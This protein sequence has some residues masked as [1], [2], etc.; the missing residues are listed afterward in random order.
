MCFSSSQLLSLV[1]SVMKH[2]KVFPSWS[3]LFSK[4]RSL[5]GCLYIPLNNSWTL[6]LLWRCKFCFWCSDVPCVFA[7]PNPQVMKLKES[8]EECVCYSEKNK[9]YCIWGLQTDLVDLLKYI[10]L[11]YLWKNVL[12]VIFGHTKCINC[13]LYANTT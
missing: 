4:P 8:R 1:I 12:L 6:L 2:H 11:Q 9:D 13:F 3:P 10:M 5:W 7:D